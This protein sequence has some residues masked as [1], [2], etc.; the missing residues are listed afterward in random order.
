MKFGKG[1]GLLA[2]A[3]FL[4]IFIASLALYDRGFPDIAGL[5]WWG[6]VLL[7]SIYLAWKGWTARRAENPTAS[8]GGWGAVL[9][10]TLSRWT[11]GEDN[12]TT[13]RDR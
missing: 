8:A 6:L 10:P 4:A 7:A 3:V 2:L 5:I 13:K 11:L 1:G 12:A 9:P